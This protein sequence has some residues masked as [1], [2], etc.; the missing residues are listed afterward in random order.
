RVTGIVAGVVQAG[1]VAVFSAVK[2]VRFEVYASGLEELQKPLQVT[3]AAAAHAILQVESST[4]V[5]GRLENG[6]YPSLSLFF[7]QA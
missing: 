4:H 7:K 5:G 2:T 6:K 3:H 1:V